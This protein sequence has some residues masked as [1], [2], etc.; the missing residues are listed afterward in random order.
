MKTENVIGFGISPSLNGYKAE[1]NLALFE[2]AEQDF[3]A[4]SGVRSVVL[5]MAPRFWRLQMRSPERAVTPIC[6]VLQN[7]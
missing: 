1:Q 5:A 2:R 3:A 6:S 4:V 7:F